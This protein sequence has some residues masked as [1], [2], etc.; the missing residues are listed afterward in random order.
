MII[1]VTV[2][3]IT[4]G[5]FGPFLTVGDPTTRSKEEEEKVWIV[6][7]LITVCVTHSDSVFPS[8]KLCPT[9]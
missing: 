7:C 6:L 5:I 1:F 4:C 9:R 3:I 8:H 2:Y